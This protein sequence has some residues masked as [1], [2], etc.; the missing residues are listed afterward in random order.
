MLKK[1][2]N[3]VVMSG[4]YKLLGRLEFARDLHIVDAV[5]LLTSEQ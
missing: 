2:A 1:F 4:L 5:A 3:S